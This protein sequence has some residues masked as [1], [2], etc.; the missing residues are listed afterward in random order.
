MNIQGNINTNPALD[1]LAGGGNPNLSR[2]YPPGGLVQAL[3]LA[4]DTY[5]RDMAGGM[6]RPRLNAWGLRFNGTNN[7]L[8]APGVYIEGGKPIKIKFHCAQ[9]THGDF[10][11][12]LDTQGWAPS[13]SKGISLSPTAG[14]AELRILIGNGSSNFEYFTGLI[15]G[16]LKEYEIDFEWSGIA[17]DTAH[18]VDRI[19]GEEY[20]VVIGQSW[21][22]NSLFPITIGRSARIANYYFHGDVY[23]V[24]VE[25]GGELIFGFT[26]EQQIWYDTDKI[27]G[28][29]HNALYTY[30]NPATYKFVEK[31]NILP[32]RNNTIGYAL[33][34][35]LPGLYIPLTNNKQPVLPATQIFAGKIP[36]HVDYTD[37]W[38]FKADGDSNYLKLPGLHDA[39]SGFDYET[40][41]YAKSN[42]LDN[43]LKRIFSVSNDHFEIAIRDGISND[44]HISINYDNSWHNIL[45]ITEGYQKIRFKYINGN[46]E[47]YVNS[48]I[49]YDNPINLTY[50]NAAYY[51][52]RRAIGNSEP[53]F[54]DKI[55]YFKSYIDDLFIPFMNGSGNTVYNVNDS[56]IPATP[57]IIE[58]T[59][60]T[61]ELQSE[62]FFG[63]VFGFSDYSTINT[64]INNTDASIW[65]LTDGGHVIQ[66]NP[67]QVHV[68]DDE[69]INIAVGNSTLPLDNCQAGII[70]KLSAKIRKINGDTGGDLRFRING[71]IDSSPLPVTT[72]LEYYEAYLLGD[73]SNGVNGFV[74][75][76]SDQDYEIID[77]AIYDTRLIPA[78]LV[79][80]GFDVLGN[81]LT[82]PHRPF[83]ING[84]S[85]YIQRNDDLELTD[86]DK[87]HKWF[88][89][90][91]ERIGYFD[92]N[93]GTLNNLIFDEGSGSSTIENTGNS[94][95]VVC[96]TGAANDERPTIGFTGLNIITG[97]NYKI[98]FTYTTQ[99][100]L[101]IK[102]INLGGAAVPLDESL[103]RPGVF[104]YS[105]IATS[106]TDSV[107]INFD[108][109]NFPGIIYIDNV[110]ILNLDTP[111]PIEKKKLSIDD[112]IPDYGSYA[113]ANVLSPKWKQEILLYRYQLSDETKNKIIEC[114]ART[115]LP[116]TC[117]VTY[118][119]EIVTY[120]PDMR[121]VTTT[122]CP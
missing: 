115:L 122:V 101:L 68:L 89:P 119:G 43:R 6:D 59:S 95:K 74:N 39:S 109:N 8:T 13:G 80:E 93:D 10:I 41:L 38:A 47:V 70:Y 18:L 77:F 69:R 52:L 16:D 50:T 40:I 85:L 112:I 57:L 17:G 111:I 91:F 7:H 66:N 107:Y 121:P 36:Y 21:T 60:H 114:Y 62:D 14:T 113:F 92:F 88:H 99:D 67:P 94:I 26:P 55:I 49:I 71:Y 34:S 90:G 105:E 108:G 116:G 12:W 45:S 31:P 24:R 118:N 78:S 76:I 9:D 63:N 61:W 19:S 54:D 73:G 28:Y 58:G 46:L 11:N 56:A 4:R 15:I 32:A 51:L 87:G 106:D 65:V 64:I 3:S 120:L 84:G 37:A 83:G 2:C 79:N 27:L 102:S 20:S 82:N 29:L 104:E 117:L 42:Y 53:K 98:L 25:V 44:L 86:A 81:T 48:S 100:N 33:D 96:G 110:Y 5:I 103:N 23:E 1:S 75:N 35:A 72:T 97:T 22:G 30:A